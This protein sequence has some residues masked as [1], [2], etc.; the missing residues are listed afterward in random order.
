MVSC[1]PVMDDL[2][3]SERSETVLVTG[4]TVYRIGLGL[5][6]LAAAL[7]LRYS[8]ERG[9]IG[10]E[11]RVLIAGAAGITMIVAGL[12]MSS[13]R[14]TY[15]NLLQ[16][17]G[18]AIL[19]L[20]A[21]AAHLRYQLLGGTGAFLALGLVAAIVVGLA[22]RQD[23]QGLAVVGLVGGIAAPTL[24][25]GRIV[26]FPGDAG[27]LAVVVG[28]AA[29]LY[30]LRRWEIAHGIVTAGLTITV[31]VDWYRHAS[32]FLADAPAGPE[33]QAELVLLLVAGWMVPL[34][35]HR[36]S[37]LM[38]LAGTALAPLLFY[39][40]TYSLWRDELPRSI[41]VGLGLIMAALLVAAR[42]RL[43]SDP[44]LANWQLA[45]AGVIVTSSFAVGWET[46]EMV[47]V[48]LGLQA[49]AMTLAGRR[50]RLR[51]LDLAGQMLWAPVGLLW[52][53]TL[54]AAPAG[55][56]GGSVLRL[57]VV[58]LAGAQSLELGRRRADLDQAMAMVFGIGALGGS[59]VWTAL[60]LGRLSHGQAMVSAAWVVI[61]IGLVVGGRL[62]GRG[63]IRNAGL[64]VILLAIGKLLLVDLA[65]VE[66]M[67]RVALF[68][69]VGVALLALGYWLG[70]SPTR[71]SAD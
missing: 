66:P 41:W 8:I 55:L 43:G 26:S 25:P 2:V 32:P 42:S 4:K 11:D 30:L 19:Y 70:D 5:I 52:L 18:G 62:R 59:L 71:S 49:M 20:T 45:P 36:A 57:L 9:W 3:M 33:L 54:E 23:S 40:G 16:G 12:A 69:G 39:F 56:G 61:G 15:G 65:S 63:A 64:G 58:A 22:L 17:G 67:Q 38:A 10:P 14:P 50:L 37:A 34:G 24:I 21:F 60:E 13:R 6:L 28:A 68:A 47:M 48:S 1:P 35:V 7:F 44:V 46:S 27:Y 29:L 51:G 31:M 53:A